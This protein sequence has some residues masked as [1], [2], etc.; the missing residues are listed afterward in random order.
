MQATSPASTTRDGT[1]RR[2]WWLLALLA[3]GLFA[4]QLFLP[5]VLRQPST[6]KPEGRPP[7]AEGKLPAAAPPVGNE[8]DAVVTGVAASETP[9]K[10]TLRVRILATP[11]PE[12][13]L[14]AV[15]DATATEAAP[16]AVEPTTPTRVTGMELD[17]GQLGPVG[18]KGV[19][20]SLF[21]VEAQGNNFA[22]VFDRSGSMGDPDA[23]PL[24]AAKAEL[25]R[26]LAALGDLQQFQII[27]YNEEPIL[28]RLAAQPG[29]LVLATDANKA[30][31][32]D[33]LARI[34]AG[35]GTGHE[36]A[37]SA[38][39]RLHPDV[40]YFLTDADEPAL[41]EEQLERIRK[42]NDAL[43][44]VYTIE[45]GRGPKQSGAGNFIERLAKEN[46]GEYRY[47]DVETIED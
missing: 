21:G 19:Y 15:T 44:K 47:V 2:K 46:G 37:L 33:H 3:G 40:L 28:M 22:Y 23:K 13:G 45:F 12:V 14:D 41:S 36:E 31:A 9:P 35:G 7:R 11:A 27:F 38:A 25:L 8:R 4:L 39:L 18:E 5:G 42:L 17:S 34:T 30:H 32:A 20:T 26:S 6:S 10:A 16:T 43:T 29:R 1:P 24:R